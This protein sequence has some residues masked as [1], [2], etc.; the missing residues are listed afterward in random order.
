MA[1]MADGGYQFEE[2]PHSAKWSMD[3]NA[4]SLNAYRIDSKLLMPNTDVGG[5]VIY[6]VDTAEEEFINPR[7]HCI[8]WYKV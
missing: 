3:G 4:D 7:Q 8:E 6:R 1:H 2:N 5:V